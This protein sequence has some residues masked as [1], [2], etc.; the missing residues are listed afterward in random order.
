MSRSIRV[1]LLSAVLALAACG[2]PDVETQDESSTTRSEA[3]T[4]TRAA[5]GTTTAAETTTST[6]P[7]TTTT[8]AR[9]EGDSGS[10]ME[11]LDATSEVTSAR[12]EGAIEM[13]GLDESTTGVSEAVILFST[14]FDAATGNS[15]FLMDM[16]SMMGAVETDPEDPFAE[17]AAGMFSE[18]EVRQI[19]DI[20]YVKFPFLASM[21]AAET[22]W[23]SMPAEDGESFA[24]DFETM[25]TDPNEIISSYDGAGTSVEQ[26][27]TEV[28]NGVEATH[29]SISLD[30]EEMDLSAAERAELA[31]SG[32]F[33]NGV[34]PLDIW[35]SEDGYMVRMIMEIDGTGF[36]AP[37]GEEFER[38]TMR[39]DVF[40]VNDRVVIEA[41]LASDVTAVEDLEGAFGFDQ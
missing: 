29:Y 13:T 10:L 20:S 7:A 1:G 8:T 23:I 27:G 35:I 11:A 39:Y 6:E 31:E 34:V 18:M 36:D 15:S 9:A 24:A 5:P 26:V 14:A 21:M 4:T 19:G 3:V 33:V 28:V 22:E 17:M 2:G 37:Q 41:P 16:S 12:I 30:T 25:P 32:V 40:D 38:M